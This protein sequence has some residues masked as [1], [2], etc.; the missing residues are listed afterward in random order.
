MQ[1]LPDHPAHRVDSR[2][3]LVCH[4]L[5][6]R[7][8]LLTRSNQWE[9]PTLESYLEAPAAWIEGSPGWYRGFGQEMPTDGD[10]KL[11]AR[12][13]SAAVVYE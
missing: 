2:E 11:F 3:A 8:D 13:L 7:D 9:N 5:S 4:I 12:A 1:Q 10:W 6:L